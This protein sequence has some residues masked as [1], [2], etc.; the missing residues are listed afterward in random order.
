[1]E[2]LQLQLLQLQY[3][4]RRLSLVPTSN[5]IAFLVVLARERQKIHHFLRKLVHRGPSAPWYAP[6]VTP[7]PRLKDETKWAGVE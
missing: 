1:V 7:N 2:H 5:R 3:P 4:P 6:G